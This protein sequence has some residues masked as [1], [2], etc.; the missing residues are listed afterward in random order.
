MSVS[1]ATKTEI[2][3]IYAWFVE[4][5]GSSAGLD[6]ASFAESLQQLEA[7]GL[8]KLEIRPGS[9]VFSLPK[10]ENSVELHLPR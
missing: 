2:D 3:A 7:V 1:E 4:Q 5:R 10:A 6:R 9:L 8:V